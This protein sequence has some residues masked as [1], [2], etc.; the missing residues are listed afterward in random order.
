MRRL[1]ALVP[2]AVLI[3]L[4][5]MFAFFS[6]RRTPQVSPQALVGKP[7]PAVVLR[8]L[9]GGAPASVAA[10]ARGPALIN[11]YASWCVPCIQE[12][13]ALAAL[14]A[15][16]VKLVGVAY[17]DDADKSAA[18]L[19]RYGDPF[20]NVVADPDGRAGLEFGVTGVPETFAVDA[21][22]V[23]RGKHAGPMTASDAEDLIR[24]AESAR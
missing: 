11:F 17:K 16:G 22:G 21:R 23:I 20:A 13:P 6:L 15:Q 14:K 9:A 24:K 1:W 10:L 5:A 8:P 12:A 4:V 19:A 18:F 7:V 3:A 2:I